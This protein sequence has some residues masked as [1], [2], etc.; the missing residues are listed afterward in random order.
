MTPTRRR[1]VVVAALM[2][3]AAVGAPLALAVMGA[4]IYGGYFTPTEGAAVGA[5][6]T[7]VAALAK[8]EIDWPKFKQWLASEGHVGRGDLYE[9]YLVGPE[10]TEDPNAYRTELIQPLV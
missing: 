2:A 4:G 1:A 9:R 7:F 6:V 8:R 3:T 5:A 10:S